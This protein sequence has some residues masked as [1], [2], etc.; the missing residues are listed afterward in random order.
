MEVPSTVEAKFLVISYLTHPIKRDL[1]I[2]LYYE[3]PISGIDRGKL[4]PVS[5]TS[6]LLSRFLLFLPGIPGPAAPARLV[7]FQE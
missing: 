1:C 4:E 2:K 6:S 7:Q 3:I 5:A